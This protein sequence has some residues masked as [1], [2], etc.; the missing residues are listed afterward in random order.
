MHRCMPYY[1]LKKN[2][3]IT[4]LHYLFHLCV[5]TFYTCLFSNINPR[6]HFE[7]II[8]WMVEQNVRVFYYFCVSVFQTSWSLLAV[9]NC[10][11]E[12][13]WIHFFSLLL[14]FKF[15]GISANMFHLFHIKQILFRW[16]NCKGQLY[17][18]FQST[19]NISTRCKYF[20]LT[21]TR[22]SHLI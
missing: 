3:A 6:H 13:K 2:L 21:K 8:N 12:L 5:I 1:Q 17:P 9:F 22:G 14:L 18:I 7:N 11:L 20:R 19:I 16:Q 15:L 10:H 4:G